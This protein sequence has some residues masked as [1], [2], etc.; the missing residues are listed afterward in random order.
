V[1]DVVR[2][3][4]QIRHQ[5]VAVMDWCGSARQQRKYFYHGKKYSPYDGS[6]IVDGVYDVDDDGIFDAISRACTVVN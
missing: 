5:F 4:L 3:F 6:H 1:R 2:C